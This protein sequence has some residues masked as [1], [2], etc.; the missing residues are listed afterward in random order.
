MTIELIQSTQEIFDQRRHYIAVQCT[1][2]I[3]LFD[4]FVTYS[5]SQAKCD[6][7]DSIDY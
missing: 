1:H 6:T 7:I 3:D 5:Q 4:P 2:L